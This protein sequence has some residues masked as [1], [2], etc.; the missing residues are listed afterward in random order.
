MSIN[1]L[2][3]I[4]LSAAAASG[5]DAQQLYKQVGPDGKVTFTDRQPSG[6]GKVSVMRSNVLRPL[7]PDAPPASKITVNPK[8]S[9]GPA[10]APTGSRA[11]LEEAVSAVM[12]LSEVARKF[13]PVCS[14]TPQAAKE[15]SVA[16]NAWR[17]RNSN[18][19]QLHTRILMQVIDPTRRAQMQG[20]IG[21][22]VDEALAEVMRLNPTWRAKWCDKSIL[23]MT[24]GSNDIANNA[25][26]A[27]PLIT[28]KFK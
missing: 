1:K 6:N 11:E 21:G 23:D 3:L 28:Y 26:V 2:L 12:L 14:P 27:V 24:S 8:S 5:A 20:K 22:R 17:M 7:E 15:Y 25:A 10:F 9:D 13:D 18:F 19:L 4:F 16:V